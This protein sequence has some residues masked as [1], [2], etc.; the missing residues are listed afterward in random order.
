MT[1]QEH[2]RTASRHVER[3]VH[4]LNRNA[5]RLHHGLLITDA[6]WPMAW[7]LSTA[8]SH[9]NAAERATDDRAAAAF[10]S[11]AAAHLLAGVAALDARLMLDV[12]ASDED[13]A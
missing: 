13:A 5:E 11:H 7:R 10:L 9:M 8:L 6:D 3:Q 4:Q 1:W 2:V 12:T